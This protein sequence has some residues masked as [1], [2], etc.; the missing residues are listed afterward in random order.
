MTC[1]YDGAGWMAPERMSLTPGT[2]A[3]NLSHNSAREVT[4]TPL[5][6]LASIASQQGTCFGA[7]A[8]SG[9]SSLNQSY[10]KWKSC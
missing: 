1:A 5:A 3:P 4:K 7:T 6:R 8:V 10:V 2:L 9:L